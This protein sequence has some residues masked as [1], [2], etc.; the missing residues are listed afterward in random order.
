MSRSGLL[1][2]GV[3]A[4]T[5]ACPRDAFALDAAEAR[6]RADTEVR[7]VAGATGQV[8]AAVAKARS[9]S[10][11]SPAKRV[12]SGEIMLRS[13]DY[14]RAIRELSKVV[15]LHRQ[16]K[17]SAAEHADALFLLAE[18][19]FLSDQLL[20]A[21]RHYTEIVEGGAAMTSYAG[22]SLSRLVDIAL[23]TDRLETLDEVMAHL[24]KLPAS[25][26]TGSLQY[27]RGKAH[28][29]KREFTAARSALAQVAPGSE[30]EPQAKYL[31][32][33]IEVK[34]ATPPPPPEPEEGAAAA[35][36]AQVP[37][38]RYAK[39]VEAFRQVTQL[40]ADND[41]HRHVVDLAWMALGRLFYESDSY[42]DAVQA[43]S[44]VDRRSPEFNHMLYELAWV[45]VRLG[46]YQ[47]AERALE[48]LAISDPNSLRFA[49][50]SLLRADLLLRSGKFEPAL[51][52]Y[53]G[54]RGQFDPI[55]TQVDR[56]LKDT[57][58]PT[59][60]YEKLTDSER[61]VEDGELPRVALEWAREVAEGDRVFS[62]IDDVSQSRELVRDSRTLSSKL[63]VVLRSSVR[64][65]AFPEL[66]AGMEQALALLNRITLA[67]GD[68]ALGLEDV[69]SSAQ[70]G[71]LG[72][73]RARRRALMKQLS[74]LPRTE[75]D[76]AAR[77]VSGERQ[78]NRVSQS[79]QQLTIAADGLQ[80]VINGL[81]RVMADADSHGVQQDPEARKRFEAEIAA[82]ERDLQAY[83][84][85]IKE[86]R[87]QIELGRVQV[88][89]GDQRYVDDAKLRVAFREAL[90]EEINLA[91]KAGGGL[92]AYATSLQPVLERAR[93]AERNVQE[94]YDRLDAQVA[95]QTTRLEQQLAE[96]SALVERYAEQLESLDQQA[97]VLVGEVAMKHFALVRDR[98]KSIVLRADTGV[99]QHA[100]E[101]REEA[102][103][104][105]TNLQRERSREEASLNDEL[106]EVIDDAGDDE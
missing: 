62:M 22:R 35:P 99:V 63:R 91:A 46:D 104:R 26:R 15:E 44:H 31:V 97:R 56:F 76:F 37:R 69:D 90:T 74:G 72:A 40:K 51:Q 32:G 64:A 100:W 33:A 86:Y 53:Q 24:S 98:L 94:A 1:L 58:D 59:V 57:T 30:W 81:K 95:S 4:A 70:S 52:L 71:A 47:R 16:G 27:A 92:A 13:K 60:Y 42:L 28:Y 36:K 88:G 38:A 14:E 25:D 89:F 49:D 93:A 19:Y 75:G 68:L 41:R 45:Y 106:R 39:A 67:R 50:G 73:A 105:V 6:G 20:S 17:A 12:V 85:R 101:V 3:L 103:T 23:R 10:Q 77:E 79:L 8:Q 29:T 48:V 84:A 80:A 78:W 2:A 9:A 21:R 5:V 61:T 83:R 34:E 65:K 87:R 55:H 18:A 96:E 11:T 66:K 7:A 43:Y 82:N 102:R 54:V